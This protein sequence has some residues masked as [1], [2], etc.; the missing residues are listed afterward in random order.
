VHGILRYFGIGYFLVKEELFQP[1]V[2]VTKRIRD[3]LKRLLDES[4]FPELEEILPIIS[5]MRKKLQKII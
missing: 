1:A 3:P 2:A 5:D 4:A